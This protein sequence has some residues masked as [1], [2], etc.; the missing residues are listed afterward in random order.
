MYT[1]LLVAVS[2][3][4]AVE[5]GNKTRLKYE[6]LQLS[7]QR[8]LSSHKTRLVGLKIVGLIYLMYYYLIIVKFSSIITVT[9]CASVNQIASGKIFIYYAIKSV[10]I[11][12][13]LPPS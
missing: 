1:L 8:W 6:P 7:Y 3:D 10:Y 11:I 2:R 12:Q 4:I 9:N 13:I 5:T